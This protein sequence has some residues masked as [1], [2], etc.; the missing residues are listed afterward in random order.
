MR[1]TQ[2][3][4]VYQGGTEELAYKEC[5][6]M[7]Y[8]PKEEVCCHPHRRPCGVLPSINTPNVRNECL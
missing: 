3:S 8:I 1:T 4:W 5:D 7:G 6:D 2:I